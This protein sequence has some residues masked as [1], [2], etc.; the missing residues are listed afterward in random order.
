MR[1]TF[2]ETL[3]PQGLVIALDKMVEALPD[4]VAAALAITPRLAVVRTVAELESSFDE[5]DR[6]ITLAAAPLSHP[7]RRMV[8]DMRALVW[9]MLPVELYPSSSAVLRRKEGK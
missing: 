6:A 1:Q 8:G 5:I 2:A 7:S 3:S 9:A 4:V